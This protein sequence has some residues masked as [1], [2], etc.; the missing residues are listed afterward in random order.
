[1]NDLEIIKETL[2]RCHQLLIAMKIEI[3]KVVTAS[4]DKQAE[5]MAIMKI[6]LV[7]Y[8]QS[9]WPDRASFE[10]DI[11]YLETAIYAQKHD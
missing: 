7:G 10:K 2:V 1:M 8:I 11:V 6:N 9:I 3:E 5:T 4:Q